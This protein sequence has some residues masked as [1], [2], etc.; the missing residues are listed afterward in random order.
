MYILDFEEKMKTVVYIVLGFLIIPQCVSAD[1]KASDTWANVTTRYIAVHPGTS[2]AV[3]EDAA[4][5]QVTNG[6]MSMN[7]VGDGTYESVIELNIGASYNFLYFVKTTDTAP[8]GLSTW[9]TYYDAVPTGGVI[10]SGTTPAFVSS[11]DTYYQPVHYGEV[12]NGYSRDARRIL[13]VPSIL[14]PYDSFY[15]YGNWADIPKAPQNFT[16]NPVDTKTV[17]LSWDPPYGPWGAS[18]ESFKAIDVIVGGTYAIFRN[19]TGSTSAYTLLADIDGGLLSYTDSTVSN[20]NTY[21]YVIVAHDAYLGATGESFAQLVSDTSSQDSAIIQNPIPVTFKVENFDWDYVR[22]NRQI[23]YL[24]PVW[25]EKKRNPQRL[26]GRI[27]NIYIG[28][29]IGRNPIETIK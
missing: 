19:T 29:N 1:Y 24:T 11:T 4:K 17:Y 21:W 6:L 22:H 3:W 9:T 15:I 12:V 13:T 27:V 23:V 20:G 28:D 10:Q 26:R 18:G 14:A 5:S 8:N 2:E 25:E 16:A 7:P